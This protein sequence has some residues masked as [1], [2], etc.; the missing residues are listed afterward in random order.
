MVQVSIVKSGTTSNLNCASV[1]KNV[2]KTG[3][4]AKFDNCMIYWMRWLLLQRV[5]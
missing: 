4:K 1:S 5:M 3:V 2:S